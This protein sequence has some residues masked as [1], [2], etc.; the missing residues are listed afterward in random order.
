MKQS[1][2]WLVHD[3]SLYEGLLAR[4]QEA[5][6]MEDWRNANQT[7]REMVTQLKQHMAIED[8][9]LYPAY[10][11]NTDAPQGPTA[12]LRE[13]HRRILHLVRD[14][15]RLLQTSDSELVLDSLAQLEWRMLKHHEKEEDIFLPM[16]S[17]ILYEK[18][19]EI[20]NKLNEFDVSKA[21]G[22][23]AD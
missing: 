5:V 23:Y 4:C 13:E 22:K 7:F 18:R 14:M 16:A 20:L 10:E 15:E 8:E 11:A 6:E 1:E 19:E 3:H 12:A 2:T 9:V 21:A 17:H